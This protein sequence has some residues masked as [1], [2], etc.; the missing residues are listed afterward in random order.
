MTAPRLS[1]SLLFHTLSAHGGAG[2]FHILPPVPDLYC[3]ITAQWNNW[4]RPSRTL[5]QGMRESSIFSVSPKNTH[6]ESLIFISRLRRVARKFEREFQKSGDFIMND[7]SRKRIH[8]LGPLL[9]AIILLFAACG[10][11]GGDSSPDRPA[12]SNLSYSPVSAS[13]GSMP[14]SIIMSFDFTDPG[15]NISTITR[16][17]NNPDGTSDSRTYPLSLSGTTQGRADI[18]WTNVTL[19]Q[20]GTYSGAIYVTDSNGSSSNQ[21]A[22]TFTVTP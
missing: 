12:I 20:S 3:T 16:V 4:A 22:A 7:Q 21:L 9:A 19:P 6:K 13:L 1:L 14:I 8:V 11:G 2:V 10:G 5:S 15:G 17:V 18:T